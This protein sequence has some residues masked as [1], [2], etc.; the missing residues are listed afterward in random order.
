LKIKVISSATGDGDQHQYLLSYV[1]NQTVAIDA[2]CI[3]LITPLEEQL[4]IQHIF[5]SHSH[6]DHTASL[7][8]FLDNVYFPGPE[9]PSV[10]GH[11]ATLE[12]LRT[13]FF[14]DR[15]WPD[16]ARLSRDES[17]F[18]R[19]YPVMESQATTVDG[20]TITPI[21]LRHIV[22]TFGYTVSDGSCMVA[23]VSDT[24]PSEHIWHVLNSLPRLDALFLE[25]SFP[26]SMTWL[27]DKAMHL[28]PKMFGDELARLQRKVP[29]LAVHVKPAF[30][31]KVR[32][33]VADLH[34]HQV[35]FVEPG[36]EYQF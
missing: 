32:Q 23:I 36:R 21:E 20:L 24:S 31:A 12:S 35:E 3:G 27:A 5:L 28:T 17:P 9:C 4:R 22:P 6:I 16:L 1:C 7:P 33:E 8:Q 18:L 26:N 30:R 34:L 13:D 10:Y 29:T 19:M 2:G 25:V 14:N 11:P 15:V